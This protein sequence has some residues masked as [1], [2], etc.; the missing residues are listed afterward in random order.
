MPFPCLVLATCDCVSPNTMV[1]LVV[2]RRFNFQEKNSDAD[3][4]LDL[5]AL[6]S[7][8]KDLTAKLNALHDLN[9]RFRAE[10]AKVKAT[11]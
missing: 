7:Q 3:P 9:E 8:N 4:T 6:V 2:P 5:K 11:L 10:N 1:R